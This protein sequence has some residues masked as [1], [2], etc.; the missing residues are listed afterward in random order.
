LFQSSL[1]PNPIWP[2]GEDANEHTKVR[3]LN[4]VDCEQEHQTEID[5]SG[6]IKLQKI[7]KFK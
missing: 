4:N 2:I 6:Q 1:Q 5:F 7:K 3:T